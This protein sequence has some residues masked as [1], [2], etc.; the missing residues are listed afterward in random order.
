MQ[1]LLIVN[2]DRRQISPLPLLLK[3]SITI[4]KVL[5]ENDLFKLNKEFSFLKYGSLV[6]NKDQ[7]SIWLC[8]AVTEE[9]EDAS[10]RTRV[11]FYFEESV[12]FLY[13][14]IQIK[15]IIHMCFTF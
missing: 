2:A 9:A 15:M 14:S 1:V 8:A 6:R 3:P 11:S 5:H 4:T 10:G 12:Y 13:T 7:M